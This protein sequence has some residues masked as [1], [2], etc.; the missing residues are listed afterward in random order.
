[1]AEQNFRN[2]NF[3]TFLVEDEIFLEIYINFYNSKIEE[4]ISKKILF[5]IS[6]LTKFFY[7]FLFVGSLPLCYATAII[8]LNKKSLGQ[9]RKE[10]VFTPNCCLQLS[11]LPNHG[12][13]TMK[14]QDSILSTSQPKR[15]MVSSLQPPIYSRN[16]RRS[17]FKTIP[18]PKFYYYTRSRSLRIVQRQSIVFLRNG[19]IVG[20]ARGLT[21]TDIQ[22][23]NRDVLA[24]PNLRLR[25]I[26]KPMAGFFETVSKNPRMARLNKAFNFE[27]WENDVSGKPKLIFSTETTYG[28]YRDNKSVS[29][30]IN[31]IIVKFAL[32]NPNLPFCL[33]Y[34]VCDAE[35]PQQENQLDSVLLKK[36]DAYTYQL[37]EAAHKKKT[38]DIQLSMPHDVKT[39]SDWFW[40]NGE[41]TISL[42]EKM[43][44]KGVLNVTQE[45]YES[46]APAIR[47]CV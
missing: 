28:R 30:V 19:Q 37:N 39:I 35:H 34:Q 18:E 22:V 15:I 17:S 40:R 8:F 38:K 31:P 45:V 26:E 41:E 16:L 23:T 1:M 47:A 9:I 33:G 7:S 24:M 11:T 25:Q 44:D 13:F 10:T 14:M 3:F 5:F 29:K 36:S 6:N 32:E 42:I 4:F 43:Y 20:M 27:R 21:F 46:F 12:G 2:D